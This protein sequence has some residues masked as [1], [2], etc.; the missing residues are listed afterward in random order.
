MKPALCRRGNYRQP[1]SY[2]GVTKR[3]QWLFLCQL[4][5]PVLQIHAGNTN[6]PVKLGKRA[7]GALVI[8]LLDYW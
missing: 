2:S 3:E 8:G 7:W 4:I 6:I 5:L 1:Q